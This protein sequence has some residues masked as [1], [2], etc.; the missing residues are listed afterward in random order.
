MLKEHKENF[1]FL[2]FN[3]S[4]LREKPSCSLWLIKSDH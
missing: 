1:D 3:R 2:N 4:T